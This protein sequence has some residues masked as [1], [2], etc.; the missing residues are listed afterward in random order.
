MPSVLLIWSPA[1]PSKD[2][3]LV[4]NLQ[5]SPPAQKI[6]VLPLVF[7]VVTVQDFRFRETSIVVYLFK[8]L[9]RGGMS[10]SLRGIPRRSL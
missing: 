9:K 7:P 6:L 5:V 10:G 8:V 4:G 1:P 2:S 3:V